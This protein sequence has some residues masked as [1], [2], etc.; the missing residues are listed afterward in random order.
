MLCVYGYVAYAFAELASSAAE[1]LGLYTSPRFVTTVLVPIVGAVPDVALTGSSVLAA[2]SGSVVLVGVGTLIGSIVFLQTVP[3][4]IAGLIAR[5][6]FEREH[7]HIKAVVAA[8]PHGDDNRAAEARDKS[9]RGRA[10]RAMAE[11]A[12]RFVEISTVSSHTPVARGVLSLGKPR[13]RKHAAADPSR[14]APDGLPRH[15]L[16]ANTR[17]TLAII[18]VTSFTFL[19]V[20]FP[21]FIGAAPDFERI[22]L[23]VL[24]VLGILLA[25]AYMAFLVHDSGRRAK[26]SAAVQPSGRGGTV[27]DEARAH[28]MV[29]MADRGAARDI[30][31]VV[32]R[33]ATPAE[34]RP[35]AGGAHW[36]QAF[37][38]SVQVLF[39]LGVVSVVSDP[40][41]NTLDT[42]AR[43]VGLHT[44]YV[45]YMVAPLVSNIGEV[46]VAAAQAEIAFVNAADQL[47][48]GV[49]LENVF[50]GPAFFIILYIKGAH[51]TYPTETIV[52]VTIQLVLAVYFLWNFSVNRVA[53][54]PRW[55]S[56]LILLV[57][58]ASVLYI[59]LLDRINGLADMEG[60][61]P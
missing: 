20:Q 24:G 13:V 12:R 47:F 44:F 10:H 45:S 52:I 28:A 58:P 8:V 27:G 3:V 42:L 36:L 39:F 60:V 37:F 55:H 11:E 54:P 49:V 7:E 46:L 38:S 31:R 22:W 51:W 21:D 15:D 50:V 9:A 26:G 32:G 19:L 43:R 6:S 35:T 2:K 18:L 1:R 16:P 17:L 23:L 59:W 34:T 48:N 30:A 53:G 14:V 5:G 29:Q 40:F 4:G 25:V 56:W 61:M 41:V 33:E 57:F